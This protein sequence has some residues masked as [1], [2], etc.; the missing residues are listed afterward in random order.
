MYTGCSH[1]A[2]LNNYSTIPPL[3]ELFGLHL[4]VM[5]FDGCLSG[6]V[7][8]FGADIG[9]TYSFDSLSLSL[10]L[11][12]FYLNQSNGISWWTNLNRNSANYMA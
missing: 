2:S 5:F 4:Y 7:L 9:C 1:K 12:R 11:S 6:I 10:S 8:I 3:H